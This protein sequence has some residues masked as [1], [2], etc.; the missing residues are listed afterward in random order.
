KTNGVLEFALRIWGIDRAGIACLVLCAAAFFSWYLLA[1]GSP[2]SRGY[3]FFVFLPLGV[4]YLGRSVLRV[5]RCD[6][7]LTGN[8][9]TVFLAGSV[10]AAVLLLV[11]QVVFPWSVRWRSL[12]RLGLSL[13]APLVAPRPADEEA[14]D[15][16]AG[17]CDLL[18][19]LLSL[20]AATFWCQDLLRPIDYAADEIVFPPWQDHFYHA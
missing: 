10:S 19:V 8:F 20:T 18:A 3:L 1:V 16:A 6:A 2:P 4:Y 14:E 11:M 17:A 7:D 9:A 13:L 5:S 12:L 15:R